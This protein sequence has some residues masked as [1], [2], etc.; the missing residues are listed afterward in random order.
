VLGGASV[1]SCNGVLQLAEAAGSVRKCP[2]VSEVSEVSGRV[3][4]E[5]EEIAH[6]GGRHCGAQ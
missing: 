6:R 4:T 2:D 3:R 1:V 5:S